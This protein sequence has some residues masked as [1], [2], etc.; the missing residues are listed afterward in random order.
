VRYR[1]YVSHALMQRR[2]HE[3]GS[4]TRVPA[5]EIESLVIDAIRVQSD[6]RSNG[7][8]QHLV[9]DRDLIE[10]Q[11]ERI[12]IKP[13]A[14]EIHLANVTSHAAED[15]EADDRVAGDDKLQAPFLSVPWVGAAATALKGIL[16]LPSAKTTM[17]PESRDVLLSAI[18][19]ARAWI[20]DLAEGRV[21]SFAEIAQREG[22][23]E[24]HVRFLAPLAFASPGIISAI[25][26]GS[27]PSSL[28]MTALVK[29]MAY[30][31]AEQELQLG[32][33]DERLD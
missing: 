7:E 9:G 22:K 17:S 5:H 31:W 10:Q 15:R 13:Q 24:A 11:V 26:A 23:V 28:K 19:K 14:I 32:I 12:I 2:K 16:H 27:A 18:A 3:A 30:L 25:A 8:P 33:S 21:T 6:N 1:Y 20:E 29:G 4:V